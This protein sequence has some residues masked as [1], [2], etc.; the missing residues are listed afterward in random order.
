M[1]LFQGLGPV[2]VAFYLWDRAMKRGNLRLVGVASYATPLLSTLLLVA[3]GNSEAT[4]QLWIAAVL[5]TAGA[6][7]G[8]GDVWLDKPRPK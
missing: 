2:G 1:I 7:L 8:G 4:P 5:V 3:S 6:A